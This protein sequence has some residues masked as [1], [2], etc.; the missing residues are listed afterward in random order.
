MHEVLLAF[1]GGTLLGLAV[2]GYL[3][4]HGRIAGISGLIAQQ[5]GSGLPTKSPAFWF[6]S[7]LILTSFVVGLFWQPEIQLNSH[8]L[9]LIVA[10]LLVGFGT[11]LG[12][13]CTS[14]HGICGLSRLSL[15]SI[16][17]T[18]TFMLTGFITVYVLRHI[19]GGF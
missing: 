7:G 11:R 17:A 15:R 3:Y 4:V 2:V 10:G 12:S 14:G 1:F 9:I 5:F 19:I 18:F 8:P 13:G 6:L 16:M